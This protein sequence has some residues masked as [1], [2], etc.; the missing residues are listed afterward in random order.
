MN[1]SCL[2][3][4]TKKVVNN[5]EWDGESFLDPH[6]SENYDLI[7]WDENTKGFPV[8]P[9]DTYDLENFGFISPKPEQNP[10]FIFNEEIWEWVPPVPF[11]NDG[12]KYNWSEENLQWVIFTQNNTFIN[13]ETELQKLIEQ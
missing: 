4:D 12:G 1:Y 3:K 8:N 13:L 2:D 10:S 7:P 5:I 9:G 6:W 11:P